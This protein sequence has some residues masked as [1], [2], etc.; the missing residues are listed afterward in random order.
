[1]SKYVRLTE[2]SMISSFK[3]GEILRRSELL[4]KN[5]GVS[6][7]RFVICCDKTGLP[8]WVEI[9][10]LIEVKEEEAFYHFI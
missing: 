4:Y 7:R 5:Y 3:K 2:D 10:L 8:Q 1:M 6:K 9:N